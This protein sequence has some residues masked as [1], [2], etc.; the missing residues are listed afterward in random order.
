MAAK[1]GRVE[2]IEVL[3]DDGARLDEPAPVDLPAPRR[4]RWWI[5]PA[6]IAG[7][8]AVVVGAGVLSDSGP[9]DG[10]RP[11]ETTALQGD[12]LVTPAVLP[13]VPAT[14]AGY[15]IAGVTR[16][17]ATP[18]GEARPVRQLWATRPDAAQLSSWMEIT[19][20]PTGLT[21]NVVGDH[22]VEVPGGIAVLGTAGGSDLTITGPLAGGGE[23]SISSSGV[24]RATLVELLGSL[25]FDGAALRSADTRIGGMFQQVAADDGSPAATGASMVVTYEAIDGP[26]GKRD[27]FTVTVGPVVAPYDETARRFFLDRPQDITVDAQQ[28]VIGGE[29]GAGVQSVSFERAGLRILVAGTAPRAV[30]LDATQS[31]HVAT[32]DELASLLTIGPS[33]VDATESSGDGTDAGGGTGGG[34]GVIA[35]SGT[36]SG[37]ESY[38]VTL[39]PSGDGVLLVD[40]TADGNTRVA[41]LTPRDSYIATVASPTMT[42]LVAFVGADV[43]GASLV[44]TV[45]DAGSATMLTA[46]PVELPGGRRAAAA[47]AFDQLAP[48]QASI[49]TT[50]GQTLSSVAG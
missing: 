28:A 10:R 7:I 22:R 48:Y 36:L 42:A 40:L 20:S 8:A 2:I 15:R 33:P 19:A 16:M 29:R 3:P 32:G 46:D 24:S 26:P 1:R 34:G 38:R 17:A 11:S 37:G 27:G 41:R 13:L 30:L 45:G 35:A 23:A 49:H 18:A 39:V 6:A 44:A 14:P 12:A 21:S 5:A 31:V 43:Q 50:D 47:V 4:R 25:R 9:S